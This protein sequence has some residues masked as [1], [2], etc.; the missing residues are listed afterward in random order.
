[1]FAATY[2]THLTQMRVREIWPVLLVRTFAVARMGPLSVQAAAINLFKKGIY[3]R[4]L[5][6]TNW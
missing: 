2:I 1:M 6:Y 3:S 5:K 4:V